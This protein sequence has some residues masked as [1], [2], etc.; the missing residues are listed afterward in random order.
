MAHKHLKSGRGPFRA[1]QL[2]TWLLSA[3]QVDDVTH[4]FD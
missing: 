1:D 2:K 4:I 3:A